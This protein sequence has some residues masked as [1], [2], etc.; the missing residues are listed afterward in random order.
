MSA[1]HLIDAYQLQAIRQILNRKQHYMSGGDSASSKLSF[2][3]GGG[4]RSGL[5]R[6]G[7]FL[8]FLGEENNGRVRVFFILAF[9]VMVGV[10]L[11]YRYHAKQK[12]EKVNGDGIY[13][14]FLKRV[15]VS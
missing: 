4:I 11:Y 12:G 6:M 2:G 9:F 15:G 3:I 14:R 8:G 1:P 7:S 13:A 10:F 5:R